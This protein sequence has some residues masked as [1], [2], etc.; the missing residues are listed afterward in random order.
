MLWCNLYSIQTRILMRPSIIRH[1]YG[2]YN[3]DA[4]S[5]Q[6][7]DD[8]CGSLND[9]QKVF[10][11]I[12]DVIFLRLYV[13]RLALWQPLSVI[14]LQ[15]PLSDCIDY[16][17]DPAS[18]LVKLR[19]L[20]LGVPPGKAQINSCWRRITDVLHSW[21]ERVHFGDGVDK[22]GSFHTVLCRFNGIGECVDDRKNWSTKK[23]LR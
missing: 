20:N 22:L 19:F 14:P 3:V 13:T 9:P 5:V 11:W 2:S 8:C 17:V 10:P 18:S 23:V 7:L 6:S 1:S 15:P 16:I 4:I 12:A 21:W